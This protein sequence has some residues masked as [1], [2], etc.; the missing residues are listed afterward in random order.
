MALLY[1]GPPVSGGMRRAP[2]AG[3]PVAGTAFAAHPAAANAVTVPG[4]AITGYGRPGNFNSNRQFR[5]HYRRNNAY[6]DGPTQDIQP[7]TFQQE[8]LVTAKDKV[9]G[10]FAKNMAKRNSYRAEQI[11]GIRKVHDPDEIDTMNEHPYQY[12]MGNEKLVK[13]IK[14]TKKMK[15]ELGSRPSFHDGVTPAAIIAQNPHTCTMA[16]GSGVVKYN[17]PDGNIVLAAGQN[18][19]Y[20]KKGDTFSPIRGGVYN[21]KAKKEAQKLERLQLK[22]EEMQEGYENGFK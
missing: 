22:R 13:L 5:E 2:L 18:P 10:R 17:G 11:M 3:A 8:L 19:S 20:V 6:F 12:A 16:E 7:G 21:K 4:R 9:A 15:R 1:R 14:R